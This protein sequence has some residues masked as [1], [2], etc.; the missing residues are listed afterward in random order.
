MSCELSD[1]AIEK[2]TPYVVFMDAPRSRASCVS[3]TWLEELKNGEICSPKCKSEVFKLSHCPHVVVMMNAFPRRDNPNKSGLSSDRHVCLVTDKEGE[4]GKWVEGHKDPH[5]LETRLPG[6]FQSR[7]P[8][9]ILNTKTNRIFK[10]T[11]SAPR[12]PKRANR[13][14]VTPFSVTQPDPE[15]D[16]ENVQPEDNQKNTQSHFPNAWARVKETSSNHND[17]SP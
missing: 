14:P 10:R 4:T 15:A 9:A 6:M 17:A 3:H 2:G 12:P 7:P 1:H 5:T 13:V 8:L 11:P 16:S